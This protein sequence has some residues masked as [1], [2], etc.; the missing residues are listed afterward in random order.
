MTVLYLPSWYPNPKSPYDGNFIQNHAVAASQYCQIAVLFC[1]SLADLEDDFRVDIQEQKN[2][3]EIRVYFPYHSSPYVRFYRKLRAYLRGFKEVGHYDLIHTHVFF[4]AGFFGAIL[5]ILKW[6]KVIHTEHSS[7]FHELNFWK[8]NLFILWKGLFAY[9]TP[10]STDLQQTLSSYYVRSSKIQV[11]PNAID[12]HHFIPKKNAKQKKMHF[13]HISKYDDERKNLTGILTVFE[14][15][16]ETYDNFF[17]EIGGDGDKIWL[18]NVV[19][20]YII[21]SDQI[22]MSG[23]YSYDELPAVFSNA[24]AFILFSNFENFGLVLA[25]SILCGTPV[26]AT[27]VGGVSDIVREQ[28]GIL[29]EKKNETQ[30]Y[31]AIEKFLKEETH[32]STLSVRNTLVD[33]VSYE[34]V[35]RSLF[36]IYSRILNNH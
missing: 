1:T 16:S 35:G 3:K 9:F 32:F 30:L 2:L 25:E 21:P 11:V 20:S 27:A 15:L 31:Q 24:D 18:K 22:S 28:N 8:K 29:V 34:Q 12:V 33:Y 4:F 14:R 5:G 19:D 17:L 6:K 7:Y 10:V 36:D 23:V 13:L 26:I